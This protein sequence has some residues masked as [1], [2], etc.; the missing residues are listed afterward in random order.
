MEPVSDTL[1]SFLQS[2]VALLWQT[3][4]HPPKGLSLLGGHTGKA[5]KQ[6]SLWKCRSQEDPALP[7]SQITPTHHPGAR[8]CALPQ[9]YLVPLSTKSWNWL[10][11]Q[12]IFDS[13]NQ[14]QDLNL[15]LLELSAWG[16]DPLPSQ[17]VFRS[18]KSSC[19]RAMH[20]FPHSTTNLHSGE[21]HS[22]L[23]FSLPSIFR[24]QTA[25]AMWFCLGEDR[26]WVL[27]SLEMYFPFFP[28]IYCSSFGTRRT[29]F[30]HE[31]LCGCYTEN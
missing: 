11:L 2:R 21:T 19:R 1:Q 14:Q 4:A 3:P 18:L 13:Q 12:P 29:Y 30:G 23:T 27:S 25:T 24:N 7:S 16:T 28:V 22:L 17:G 8:L 15:S 9:S 20:R 10:L 31:F 5:P 6:K 26:R